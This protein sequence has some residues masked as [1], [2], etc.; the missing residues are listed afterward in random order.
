MGLVTFCRQAGRDSGREFPGLRAAGFGY[1]GL[2]GP[3]GS[4]YNLAVPHWFLVAA[5]AALP[6]GRGLAL[7]RARR[8]ERAAHRGVCTRCGYD[9]RATPARCPECGTIAAAHVG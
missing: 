7:S 9:L 3:N 5:T 4:L 1:G 2:R 6:L 8:R